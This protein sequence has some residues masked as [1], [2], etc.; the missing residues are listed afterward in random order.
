MP[1]TPWPLTS[2]WAHWTRTTTESSTSWSSGSQLGILQANIGDSANNSVLRYSV[3]LP[4]VLLAC[5]SA[6]QSEKM[7]NWPNGKH[8]KVWFNCEMLFLS[9]VCVSS[10]PV[11]SPCSCQTG[12]DSVTEYHWTVS[13][14]LEPVLAVSQHT[15]KHTETLTA[16]CAYRSTR[17]LQ[18]GNAST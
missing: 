3:T 2:L 17:E 11:L 10:H 13:A 7:G 14:I 15:H 5:L 9:A 6:V 16:A 4:C 18:N 1:A 12:T 8:P